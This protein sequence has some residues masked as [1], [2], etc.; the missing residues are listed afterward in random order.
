MNRRHILKLTGATAAGLLLGCTMEGN[1][2]KNAN[3][4]DVE[5]NHFVFIDTRGKVT[6]LNRTPELG[7]GVFQAVPMIIAE[8]LEVDINAINIVQADADRNKYNRQNIGGSTTVRRGYTEL[9]EI[10]AAG[11]NM[12]MQAASRQWNCS[13]SD[14]YAELGYVYKNN[15]K[16]KL[17]YGDLAE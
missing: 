17:S 1:K 4:E 8:E 14:C 12:L 7:Q 5:L 3:I 10:G 9:R 16:D 15:S 2:V 11:K 13:I 6:I